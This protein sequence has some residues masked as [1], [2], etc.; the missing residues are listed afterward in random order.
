VRPLDSSS[1]C[2]SSVLHPCGGEG[3]AER[4]GCASFNGHRSSR[5]RVLTRI[6]GVHLGRTVAI[7]VVVR[8]WKVGGDADVMPQTSTRD[9]R[10]NIVIDIIFLIYES[11]QIIRLSG[12]PCP[13]NPYNQTKKIDRKRSTPDRRSEHACRAFHTLWRILGCSHRGEL[14]CPKL[15]SGIR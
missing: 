2:W 6:G 9:S 7:N 10:A 8:S 3:V 11:V 12:V 4:C 15:R 13:P 1:S 5:W 14:Q